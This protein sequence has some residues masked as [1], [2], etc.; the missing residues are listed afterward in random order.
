[1]GVYY[2]GRG[3]SRR[4]TDRLH[5]TQDEADGLVEEALADQP[6][7]PGASERR[8]V[9]TALLSMANVHGGL[10][11]PRGWVRALQLGF[12]DAG[13]PVPDAAQLRWYRSAV[14]RRPEAFET[15]LV[16]ELREAW[17]DLVD[18]ACR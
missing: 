17:G 4:I 5:R 13:L 10:E 11:L 9:V 16:P 7:D 6:P 2:Y 12:R 15:G 18:G 14:A 3:V 8:N 1:M